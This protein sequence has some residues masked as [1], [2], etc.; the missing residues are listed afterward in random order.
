MGERGDASALPGAEVLALIN[1][2]G[3][4]GKRAMLSVRVA[5]LNKLILAL[6]AG[7]LRLEHIYDY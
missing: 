6:A 1:R 5:E 7:P 2:D 4:G 3:F